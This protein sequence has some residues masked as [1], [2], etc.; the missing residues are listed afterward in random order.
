MVQAAPGPFPAPAAPD[1]PALESAPGEKGERAPGDILGLCG[2]ALLTACADGA[3][4]FD[5][6][7]P[8]GRKS[9]DGRAFFNGY[10]AGAAG[11]RFV[12]AE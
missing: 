8:A 10:L 5:S 4:A 2:N 6:L 3:Y 7:R 1:G 9:M 11:A 12:G